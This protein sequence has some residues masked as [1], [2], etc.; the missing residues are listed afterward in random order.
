[1]WIKE[2]IKRGNKM[3]D[4][5]N[6]GGVD[7]F[8]KDQLPEH[9]DV[10]FVFEYIS[11]RIPFYFMEGVDIIYIGRFPEM[12]ERDVNAFF[13]NGAI[14]VTNKQDDEMDLID[15]IIHEIAHAVEN[16]YQEY[17]YSPGALQREFVAKRERLEILLSQDYNVPSDFIV[18]FDYD[19]DIDNFL[20]KDVGYDNLSQ[21]AV[22]IFPSPY[23]VTSVREYWAKGF[24]EMFIGDKNQLRSLC[25]VLYKLMAGLIKELS[26]NT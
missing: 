18:N 23:A 15:D 22:N 26:E 1:M 25:P 9:I 16:N 10:S 5:F 13:E 12:K 24:E 3:R 8:I 2:S 6:L 17:I 20:Y 14:Y 19:K 4:H 7:V 21:I 11:S